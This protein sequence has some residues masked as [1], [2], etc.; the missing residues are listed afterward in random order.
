[1]DNN[2]PV[3]TSEPEIPN[4]WVSSEDPKN[5]LSLENVD[6]VCGFKVSCPEVIRHISDGVGRE[7]RA[8]ARALDLVELQIRE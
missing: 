2:L 4:Q 7:E 1:M 8:V 6:P 3:P 5:P